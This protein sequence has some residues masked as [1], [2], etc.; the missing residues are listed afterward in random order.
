V[1]Q[2]ANLQQAQKE[3]ISVKFILFLFITGLNGP[4]VD[5]GEFDSLKACEDARIGA[6]TN[7][8]QYNARAEVKIDQFTSVCSQLVVAPQSTEM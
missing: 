1:A 6:A 5:F 2:F 3:E 4:V 7:I 8:S